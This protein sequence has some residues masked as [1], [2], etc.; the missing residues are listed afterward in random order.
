MKKGDKFRIISE[1]KNYEEYMDEIWTVKRIFDSKE[2]HPLYDEAM[3]GMNLY[4][5]DGLPFL[6]YESEIEE[7]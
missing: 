3:N 1:N 7:V 5:P 2:E 6:V 4:D